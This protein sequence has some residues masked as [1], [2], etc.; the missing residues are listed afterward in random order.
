MKS[1]TGRGLDVAF[2]SLVAVKRLFILDLTKSCQST[3]VTYIS[4][5]RVQTPY[6]LDIYHAE[7]GYPG[8]PQYVQSGGSKTRGTDSLP[9]RIFITIGS[10]TGRTQPC[11]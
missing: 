11:K 4:N 3:F 9:S 2:G 5:N 6:L 1:L 7:H 10:M 8:L